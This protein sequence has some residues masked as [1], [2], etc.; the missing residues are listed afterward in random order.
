M[1]RKHVCFACRHAFNAHYNAVGPTTCP[2]CGGPLEV[3][4]HRFRPPKK[5]EEA[6]WKV[7]QYLA[8]HGF[9]YQHIYEHP[10]GGHY[11]TYPSTLVEAQDFVTTYQAQ[12]A[13]RGV[14]SDVPVATLRR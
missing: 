4:S 7:A 10:W 8:A 12:A 9:Y 11:I 14:P 5:R 2:G 6:K 3:L 13:K 1:G